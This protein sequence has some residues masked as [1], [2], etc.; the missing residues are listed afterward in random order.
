M[1]EAGAGGEA[2]KKERCKIICHVPNMIWM[3]IKGIT[4]S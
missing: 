3:S 4:K 2:R 1:V